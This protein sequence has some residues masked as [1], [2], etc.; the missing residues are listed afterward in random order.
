MAARSPVSRSAIW[1]PST[2]C[3]SPSRR[4]R[5]GS[6]A[7]HPTSRNWSWWSKARY[8]KRACATC[9]NR[10]T[11]CCAP[12]RK[13][14]HTIRRFEIIRPRDSG[15]GKNLRRFRQRRAERVRN[16]DIDFQ[17]RGRFAAV[18]LD[19]HVVG[20]E[21]DVPADDGKDFLAQQAEQVGLAA[22]PAFVGEQD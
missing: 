4:E 12:T 19:L 22:R 8:R 13:S 18:H 2:A 21:R 15:G 14:A 3:A 6:F 7:P 9:S 17:R 20:L 1:S 11:P 16:F 5:G 10:S